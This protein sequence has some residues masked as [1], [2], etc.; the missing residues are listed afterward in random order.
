MT[1]HFTRAEAAALAKAAGFEVRRGL[2]LRE[3][4]PEDVFAHGLINEEVTALCTAA[5]TAID[6][7]REA[8]GAVYTQSEDVSQRAFKAAQ[9]QQ[10]TREVIEQLVEALTDPENQPN[11]FGVVFGMHG[12]RM[13]FAIGNQSF[14]LAYEPDEPEEFEFMKR[15]LCSAFSTFTPDVK[16]VPAPSTAGEAEQASDWKTNTKS[17]A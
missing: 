4:V 12:P 13:F 5:V 9:P 17:I 14:D 16:T 6:K 7:K 10:T 8:Q 11:Q 2:G 1:E 3:S 15:M